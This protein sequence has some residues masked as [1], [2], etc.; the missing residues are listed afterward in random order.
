LISLLLKHGADASITDAD[1]GTPLHL[2][3]RA[4]R[5]KKLRNVLRILVDA[6][7]NINAARKSDG[8][9]PLI[10]AAERQLMCPSVFDGFDVDFD[11]QDSEGNTALHYACSSWCMKSQ[12]AEEWLARADPTI[13]N[14]AGRAAFTNFVWGNG[15]QG[16]IDAIA[17]MVKKGLSLESPDY[18]GRTPLLH[19]LSNNTLRGGEQFVRELLRLGADATAKDYEGKSGKLKRNDSNVVFLMAFDQ[20]SP[21]FK[22]PNLQILI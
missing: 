13:R 17:L 11:C 15:G 5:N 1:G 14:N 4:D 19:F 8:K 2:H 12:N 18:L 10:A 21:S 6:G 7:T 22:F 9:T 3:F 16:R 20:A